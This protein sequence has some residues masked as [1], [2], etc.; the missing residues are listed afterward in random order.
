[1]R[2]RAFAIRDQ[3]ADALRGINI[4]EEVEDYHHKN[5]NVKVSSSKPT[6]K[7]HDVVDAEII[8]SETDSIPNA[9]KSDPHLEESINEQFMQFMV[10]I[11]ECATIEELQSV[12]EDI[13]KFNFKNYPELLK[14]LV[15][16][17]DAVKMNIIQENALNDSEKKME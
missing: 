15:A 9:V 1:M 5:E 4:R 6:F 3:F 7:M 10:E 2:A 14:K 17:K 8:P 12:F 11:D 13:K 16:K